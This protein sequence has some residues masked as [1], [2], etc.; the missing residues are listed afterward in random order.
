MIGT[1]VI[2]LVILA[3]IWGWFR[4]QSDQLWDIVSQEC[5]PQS[6]A[7]PE[8][9]PCL[10]VVLEPNVDRGYVVFRDQ[11]GPLHFL[12]IPTT[13]IEG[14]ESPELLDSTVTDY[15]QKAWDERGFIGQQ[16]DE[17][18]PRDIVSLTINSSYGRSQDQLHIHIS[19]IKPDVKA[20]LYSQLDQFSEQWS[21][22]E[23]GINGNDYIARTLTEDQFQQMS[24]FLRLAEEVPD[25]E[26]HMGS[27]GLALVPYTSNTHV[28]M[29]LLLANKLNIL[30]LNLGYT[31]DIQDYQ[32][33]LL[34]TTGKL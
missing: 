16:S 9:S 28:P 21:K 31:G 26:N 19:C 34:K 12:L 17:P 29:Y 27:Y 10:N 23:D 25:A 5:V 30:S 7:L 22:V 33:D 11:H 20:H 13:K 1:L 2:L 8:S 24:L 14:I 15:F 32:C 6:S 3:I 4:S 18:L